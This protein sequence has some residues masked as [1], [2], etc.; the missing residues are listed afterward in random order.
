MNSEINDVKQQHATIRIGKNGL[1]DGILNE[2]KRQLKQKKIIK[3]KIAS[4]INEDRRDFAKRVA[5]I[6]E[7]ELIEVRGY[8]FIL[9]KN[10]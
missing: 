5:E 8:T 2:I 4:E 1:T 7:S 3:I 10:D 9:R 6:T